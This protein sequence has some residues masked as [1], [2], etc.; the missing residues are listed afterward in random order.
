VATT[1]QEHSL[2]HLSATG[3]HGIKT[4]E[5][6]D[7]THF[8]NRKHLKD[9]VETQLEAQEILEDFTLKVDMS[10]EDMAVVAVLEAPLRDLEDPEDTAQAAAVMVQEDSLRGIPHQIHP[11]Y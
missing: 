7:L 9:S 6:P 11:V 3:D 1:T 5:L 8:S 4:A 2:P 10:Q